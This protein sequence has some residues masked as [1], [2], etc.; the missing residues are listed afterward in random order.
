MLLFLGNA[1][2]SPCSVQTLNKDLGK[3]ANAMKDPDITRLNTHMCRKT[4]ATLML[5]S[6]ATPEQIKWAGNTIITF[7][8]W[9]NPNLLAVFEY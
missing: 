6:G 5:Q 9:H 2:N 8:I 3:V 7:F 4:G 1:I